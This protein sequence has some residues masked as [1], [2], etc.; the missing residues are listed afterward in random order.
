MSRRLLI[1]GGLCVGGSVVFGVAE[2][3]GDRTVDAE[4]GRIIT[5]SPGPASTTPSPTAS[6]AEPTVSTPRTTDQLSAKLME[7][8]RSQHIRLG[9]ALYDHTD[10]STFTYK[11]SWRTETFSIVKVLLVAAA[12]RRCQEQSL[13]LPRE[14]ADLAHAM[15]TRS[16]NEAASSLLTW[17]GVAQVRRI[18]RLFGLTHTVIQGGTTDGASDWWGYS[19]TTATDQLKL[20]R[21][22]QGTRILTRAN[23]NY[24]NHLMTEVIPS[25]RWG[26]CSPPLPSTVRWSTKNGWGSGDDGYRA[27]SIGHVTG[28]GRNYSAV[29][30]TRRPHRHGYVTARDYVAE[31]SQAFETA[32]AVSKILYAA[33]A[34]PLR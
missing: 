33:M 6:T 21:C 29:I 9:V 20:L 2:T 10:G 30:L 4:V 16:D 8:Q 15:I 17:V 23:R 14:Q 11:G 28:N 13:V 5:P 19:T 1:A 34:S 24:L 22:I 12:L 26:V 32:S 3:R 7:Y 25:Q 27:N 18:A 31:R